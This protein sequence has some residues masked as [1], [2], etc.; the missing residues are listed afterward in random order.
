[1]NLLRTCWLRL[2][3]VVFQILSLFLVIPTSRSLL[4]LKFAPKDILKVPKSAPRFQGSYRIF[5][6]A[7]LALYA[8]QHAE[9]VWKG[10]SFDIYRLQSVVKDAVFAHL[11]VC[12]IPDSV[13]LTGISI[14][15]SYLISHFYSNS[16]MMASRIID[17]KSSSPVI[18]TEEHINGS[19]V[20]TDYSG[21]H[22]KTNPKEIALVRKLDLWIMPILWVMYWL[23]YLVR[24]SM[25]F[26][27]L[28]VSY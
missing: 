17:Q 2:E 25:S 24:P 21:A 22:G 12:L 28:Y 26:Y 23:N 9:P 27:L 10:A 18:L 16:R 4:Q 1:M 13:L 7:L 19:L 14:A 11:V 6:Q 15:P 3:R 5:R 20:T 8:R